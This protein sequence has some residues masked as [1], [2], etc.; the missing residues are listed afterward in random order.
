MRLALILAFLSSCASLDDTAVDTCPSLVGIGLDDAGAGYVPGTVLRVTA[1]LA[2][3]DLD[4]AFAWTV[5][6]GTLGDPTSWETT[7]TLDPS[8]ARYRAEPAWIEVEFTPSDEACQDPQILRED[9]TADWPE[10]HRVV[11]I[12]NPEVEG[13]ED[14]AEAYA[15]LRDVPASNLC[16]VPYADP[17]TLAGADL[18]SF[19]DTLGACLEAVGDHVQ[20]LAPVYGV[21]YKVSDRIEDLA[22][23]RNA[24]V[25]LDAL[26]VYGTRA[27]D[28][29]EVDWNPLWQE[30]SSREGDYDPYVPFPTLQETLYEDEGTLYLVTRLDGADADEALS[31]VDRAGVARDLAEAG[32]L[33]GIVYVDARWTDEPSS[34]GFGSYESGDW[35][36]WGTRYVFE[37]AG[38]YEVV[39]DNHEAEF[40]TD[41]APTTCPDALY[42][43]GWYS[44]YHYNDA[45]TWMPGAIGGH[46]DS[47][48][49]CSLRDHTTWSSAALG[50]GITATFGAV[51]EP[52]VAGM[53]EYDQFFL[54]L[55]QGANY[56]E[57]A[58]EST[59]VARWMMVWV[60]DPLYRPYAEP[61][62]EP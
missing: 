39:F 26:L 20:Y 7:W 28:F 16:A 24:T 25:S 33:E 18:E 6:S 49:A 51:G 17:T 42:Y 9:L 36:L 13:S 5:S 60:G 35:N 12:W 23:G 40:G 50:R 8:L 48:S 54:Y 37:D 62:L 2:P 46:L 56:A 15:A 59:C 10:E 19:V 53:P 58:Y 27:P 1:D 11:V 22:G 43:A 41:P 57:A 44:Y 32:T 45:F 14:V 30:G 61:V 29:D 31:V 55:L 4:G 52:Y 47:C 3:A 21:P 38:L 34:D